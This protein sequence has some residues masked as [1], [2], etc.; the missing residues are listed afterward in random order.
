MYFFTIAVLR[1]EVSARDKR[2]RLFF[3]SSLIVHSRRLSVLDRS[4]RVFDLGKATSERG[5][6]AFYCSELP[7][8]EN[9]LVLDL[10]EFGANRAQMLEDKIS[11]HNRCGFN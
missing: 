8:D 10:S 9:L 5:Q 11:M 7:V 6:A 2:S 4:H 3:W 1:S